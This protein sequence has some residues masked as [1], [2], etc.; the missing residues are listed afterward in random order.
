MFVC[1]SDSTQQ[2]RS[3]TVSDNG[4]VC[5]QTIHSFGCEVQF[6]IKKI[7]GGVYLVYLRD[8]NAAGH[9]CSHFC[10]L[11]AECNYFDYSSG[12]SWY[13]LRNVC[14]ISVL[15][16]SIIHL[17]VSEPLGIWM[18]RGL[19]FLSK[20]S[21]SKLLAR[22]LMWLWLQ[23]GARFV[24][25]VTSCTWISCPKCDTCCSVPQT[26]FDSSL[27]T[28]LQVLYTLYRKVALTGAD[29]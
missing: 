10:D 25:W 16:S 11:F 29:H 12:I 21:A 13:L 15:F 8:N 7:K 23:D 9:P 20:P 5:G 18:T 28:V 26:C 6:T 1:P 17:L 14:S 3:P 2:V 27:Q 22:Q 19:P 24:D 4:D